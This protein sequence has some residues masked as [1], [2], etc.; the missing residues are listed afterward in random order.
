MRRAA[1]AEVTASIRLDDCSFLPSAITQQSWQMQ[2]RENSPYSQEGGY[3]ECSALSLREEPVSYGSGDTGPRRSRDTVGQRSKFTWRD[4][5]L[6]AAVRIRD[7]Q[8][9]PEANAPIAP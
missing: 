1:E 3:T 4:L 6:T 5:E 2:T 7:P 9:L 8:T